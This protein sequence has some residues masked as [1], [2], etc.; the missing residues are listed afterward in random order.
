[1]TQASFFYSA[2][3]YAFISVMMGVCFVLFFSS[4]HN[5]VGQEGLGP[6]HLVKLLQD[7][8]GK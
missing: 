7:L 5:V 1:M 6:R 4:Y 8:A 2:N 3:V